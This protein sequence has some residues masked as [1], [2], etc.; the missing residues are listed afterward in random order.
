[1]M[2]NFWLSPR[3]R[4]SAERLR[5]VYTDLIQHIDIDNE[6]L[7]QR[8]GVSQEDVEYHKKSLRFS[9]RRSIIPSN[10]TVTT[11]NDNTSSDPWYSTENDITTT[12]TTTTRAKQQQ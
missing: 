3:K 10:H 1:M 9:F 2:V 4:Y 6:D 8:R 11:A 12:T 5:V 7:G